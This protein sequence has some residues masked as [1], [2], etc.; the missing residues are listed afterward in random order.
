M[1]NIKK[2]TFIIL[3]LSIIMFGCKKIKEEQGKTVLVKFEVKNTSTKNL[4]IFLFKPNDS[5]FK[6]IDI[7]AGDSVFADEGFLRPAPTG[8]T[9]HLTNIL[10]SAVILFSD[11]K[12]LIQTS[13]NG[14]NIDTINNIHLSRNYQYFNE[15]N[16]DFSRQQFTITENDYLRAK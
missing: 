6:L 7:N 13:R 14:S 16:P 5:L 10:D 11:G 2:T 3:T 1:K 9:Y 8:P 4:K 15:K 12:M